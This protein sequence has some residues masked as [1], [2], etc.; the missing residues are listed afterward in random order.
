MMNSLCLETEVG[1]VSGQSFREALGILRP[2]EENINVGLV[3]L[4]L[5]NLNLLS[6]VEPLKS[7]K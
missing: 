6:C 5:Q 7:F 3:Y 4:S 2:N 1:D